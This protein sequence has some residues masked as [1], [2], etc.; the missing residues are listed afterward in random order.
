MILAILD[1]VLHYD[2]PQA[3]GFFVFAWCIFVC[4][5]WGLDPL[6]LRFYH[7]PCG[8][9]SF[10]VGLRILCAIPANQSRLEACKAR[11]F[12]IYYR[13]GLLNFFLSS[14]EC[15]LFIHPVREGLS[16][17]WTGGPLF[18]SLQHLGMAPRL[19]VHL[20]SK[21][22][23]YLPINFHWGALG[24]PHMAQLIS[25]HFRWHSE[26]QEDNLRGER[27]KRQCTLSG[28]VNICPLPLLLSAKPLSH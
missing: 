3:V 18:M 4:C 19:S 28:N 27:N 22:K 2:I 1:M 8:Q 26:E 20:L 7:W 23:G 13:S 12:R 14:L 5:V 25:S 9:G 15:S 21:W 10:L 11:V 17:P 6:V 16:L 24:P